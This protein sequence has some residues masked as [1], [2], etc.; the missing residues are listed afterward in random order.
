MKDGN[1]K[2]QK[3]KPKYNEK[4]KEIY[5]QVIKFSIHIL[6][7]WFHI[8]STILPSIGISGR[9]VGKWWGKSEGLECASSFIRWRASL[10]GLVCAS[11]E[12]DKRD[13][14]ESNFKEE[15]ARPVDGS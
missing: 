6:F 7:Y 5:Q 8:D 11:P 15:N 2:N 9:K 3:K 13:E 14:L 1:Q 12:T 10:D 4:E